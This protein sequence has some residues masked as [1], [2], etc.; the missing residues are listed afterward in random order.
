MAARATPLEVDKVLL[1]IDEMRRWEERQAELSAGPRGSRAAP[2]E[3]ARVRQQI[4]YYG[5]LLKDMKTRAHPDS[6]PRFIGRIG[7]HRG[8]P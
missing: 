6:V 1:A 8:S 5:G 3:L 7:G 4:V 2:A